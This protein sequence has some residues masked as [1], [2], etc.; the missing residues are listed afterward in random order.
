MAGAASL[1]THPEVRPGASVRTPALPFVVVVLVLFAVSGG[2]LWYLGL[3]YDGLSG[4]AAAKIHPATYLSIVLV[5][6]VMMRRGDPVGFGVRAAQARPA[7]LVLLAVA[8]ALSAHIALR[9]GS[10]LA[11][12]V[13]TFAGPALLVVAMMDLDTQGLR[14]IEGA[15]HAV[16]AANAG[17]GLAEFLTGYLV[18]P[19]RFDGAVFETDTRS[20]A[21]Q[22][23]PLAN[24]T[25]TAVYLLAVVQGGC[26]VL[27]RIVRAPMVGL[28]LAALVTFGGRSAIVVA[29]VLGAGYG[30]VAANRVLRTGRVPLLGAAFAL[31]LLT[32]A[33]LAAA[34]LAMGGFFDRLALRFVSDGGSANARIEMFDLFDR[35]PLR[36][37]MVGPDTA[38]VDSLRRI[39]GL[40][41]GIENPIIRMVLYQG[42]FMTS[43]VTLAVVLFVAEVLRW[44]RG[45]TLLPTLAFAILINT[46]ES[47]AGKTPLLTKFAVL[48]LVLYRPLPRSAP[49]RAR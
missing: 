45:G 20:A 35:I 16:M 24:A 3:N 36:D 6:W 41:W 28:Q 18:F 48:M 1:A 32:V 37:L 17:L 15:L 31:V 33:P 10:G 30:V 26:A 13:D 29:L 14:R 49:G 42:I 12:A 39:S 7:S 47:L 5:A 38:L 25:I 46:S 11:G 22:G 9:G 4:S 8:V 27:P 23:H 40:E 21:L 19:Y 34:G 44:S 2:V 43:L